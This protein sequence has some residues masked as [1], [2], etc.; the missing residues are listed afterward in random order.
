MKQKIAVLTDSSSS[1]YNVKHNF[2]HLFLIDIPV[3]LEDEAFT[4]F[5]N[6]DDQK[7]YEN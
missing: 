4:N 1:I 2:D 3:F 7:F 5:I 6:F